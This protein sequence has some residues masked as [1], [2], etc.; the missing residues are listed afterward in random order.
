MR[1]TTIWCSSRIP[2][3][4]IGDVLP[5]YGIIVILWGMRKKD[6]AKK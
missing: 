4:N 1:L 5:F 2:A 6:C 3:G